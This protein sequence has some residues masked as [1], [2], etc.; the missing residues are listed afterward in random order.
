M[1]QFL[2]RHEASVLKF[3]SQKPQRGRDLIRE[4][5]HVCDITHVV[6]GLKDRGL[7]SQLR[8]RQWSNHL[9]Q[10]SKDGKRKLQQS[11]YT[12]DDSVQNAE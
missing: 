5:A 12:L 2:G 8:C 4:F 7:V 6:A 9:Y 1:T 3:I 11:K 10:I